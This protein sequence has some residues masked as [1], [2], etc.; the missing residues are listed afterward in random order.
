VL[1][2]YKRLPSA[3]CDDMRR[4]N[5]VS[6]RPTFERRD[7]TTGRS[8]AQQ[9]AEEYAVPDRTLPPRNQRE[10]DRLL[11][12]MKGRKD[13]FLA[14]VRFVLERARDN[15]QKMEHEPCCYD[16]FVPLSDLEALTEEK[17]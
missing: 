17:E 10:Q 11:G 14:G 12:I 8:Q 13:G 1:R 15:K 2:L 6:G 9:A 7:M 3:L 4:S 5:S 16:Y